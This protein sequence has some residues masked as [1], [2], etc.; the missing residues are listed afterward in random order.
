MRTRV[1]GH[2]S[3]HD[4]RREARAVLGYYSSDAPWKSF[5]K[6]AADWSSPPATS[7]AAPGSAF[8][9]QG[10]G[11]GTGVASQLGQSPTG[12]LPYRPISPWRPAGILSWRTPAGR[13]IGNEARMSASTSCLAANQPGPRAAQRE[14]FEYGGEDPLLAA[15][16]VAAQIRGIQSITSSRPSSTTH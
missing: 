9:T 6:P 7:A 11:C 2:C 3:R 14:Q 5:K 1:P 12:G 13:M 10:D 4:S 8:R 15:N 16:I